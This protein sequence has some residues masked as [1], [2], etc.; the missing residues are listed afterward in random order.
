MM[1]KFIVEYTFND[2]TTRKVVGVGKPLQTV[3][4]YVVDTPDG[5]AVAIRK[6]N[7][8]GYSVRKY[9]ED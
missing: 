1:N 4:E 7:V 2:G 6:E 9:E 3:E 5:Q 8:R